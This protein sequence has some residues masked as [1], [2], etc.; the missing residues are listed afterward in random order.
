MDIN[1]KNIKLKK[2]EL[3]AYIGTA[4][5]MIIILLMLFFIMLPGLKTYDDDGVM[6]SFGD[7]F[8]GGGSVETP[9]PR[10][11][12]SASPKAEVKEELLT[13]KEKSV[14]IPETK[15]K[16]ESKP[17]ATDNRLKQE[18]QA[19]Q[20]AD[21]LIGGSFG[22][23]GTTGGG[24]TTGETIAGNPV[25]SGT[26]GGNSWSLSG[27]NLLGTMPT[28]AYNQNVEGYLT[29]EIRVDA[30]GNV[31]S[32]TIRRGTI[33]DQS[34]REAAINAARRT[35]FSSGSGTA[36]GTITYNFKLR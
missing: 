11:A 36:S 28:P 26:S 30:A 18:Q 23:G 33:S 21:D 24:Q 14:A 6:I 34:L 31:I 22:S 1:D 15:Q 27:R 13:Q 4:M 9:T 19:T 29:V 17:S 8:D 35:R 5:S 32:A 16:P 25:G 20:R 2:S 3:Y 10:A 7:A 12:Q